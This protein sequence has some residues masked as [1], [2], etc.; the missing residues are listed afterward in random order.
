MRKNRPVLSAIAGHNRPV[1]P[2]FWAK[3]QQRAATECWPWTGSISDWGYGTFRI[4]R[5]VFIASRV[6]FALAK[7]VEPGN[8]LVC[9]TC[10]NPA[11]CNPAHLWLGS[12]ADNH[13]DMMRKGRWRG[14]GIKGERHMWTKLNEEQVRYIK[15]SD[16]AGVVLARRFNVCNT[17]ISEIRQ[18]RNW[19]WLTVPEEKRPQGAAEL[20]DAKA[21]RVAE[22]YLSGKSA[23]EIARELG[24]PFYTNVYPLLRRAGVSHRHRPEAN[25]RR[26]A[27]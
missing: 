14:N 9:H 22:L 20:A 18:G 27:A 26:S 24:L 1:E 17:T 25:S 4:G 19:A 12:D 3:V 21:A 23:A 2:R 7:N 13:S 15:A 8:A 10:D 16:E 5:G 6:A 11:C